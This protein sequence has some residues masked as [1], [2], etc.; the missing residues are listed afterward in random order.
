MKTLLIILLLVVLLYEIYK[1]Y[2]N[3]KIIEGNSVMNDDGYDGHGG[4]SLDND[5][6]CKKYTSVIVGKSEKNKNYKSVSL[7]TKDILVDELNNLNTTS[8]NAVKSQS[9]F[10]T[11]KSGKKL[12]VTKWGNVK[13]KKKPLGWSG[14][15]TK[16]A[17]YTTGEKI[18]EPKRVEEQELVAHNETYQEVTDYVYCIKDSATNVIYDEQ[19]R[20]LNLKPDNS[21]DK[22]W[23]TNDCSGGLYYTHKFDKP[24]YQ[25]YTYDKTTY[26]LYD[27]KDEVYDLLENKTKCID[28]NNNPLIA[29][30]KGIEYGMKIKNQVNG[31]EIDETPENIK[32]F[33]NTLTLTPESCFTIG[34]NNAVN[35]ENIDYNRVF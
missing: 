22:N 14:N 24:Y 9:Q 5:S 1:L 33:D 29:F 15:L 13:N 31:Y 11:K 27:T 26:R 7:P 21:I 28:E 16:P 18:V 17:C 20:A 32:I 35:N 25:G 4:S 6:R 23:S 30:E 8:K 34:Y 3:K 10:E 19:N 12:T 2:F